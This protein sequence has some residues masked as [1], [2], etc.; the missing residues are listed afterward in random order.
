MMELSGN[1]MERTR[2]RAANSEFQE[3]HNM[4]RDKLVSGIVC[5]RS[6]E[7][8]RLRILFDFGASTS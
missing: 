7:E 6:V 3:L 1:A 2:T 8:K 4:L 5:D